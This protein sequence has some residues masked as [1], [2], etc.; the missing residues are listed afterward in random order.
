MSER[1]REKERERHWYGYAHGYGYVIYRE[2]RCID[3]DND[4]RIYIYMCV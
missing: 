1:E 3:V 2:K 4:E